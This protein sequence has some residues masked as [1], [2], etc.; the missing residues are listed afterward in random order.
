MS[1]LILLLF[2]VLITGCEKIGYIVIIDVDHFRYGDLQQIGRILK[3]EGFETVVWEGKNNIPK[4][5]NEVYSLYKKQLSDNAYYFVDVYLTYVKDVPNS[6]A[7]NF[8]IEVHNVY[9]GMNSAELKGEIDEIGDLIYQE[10]V[11]K[12]DKGNVSIKRKAH[13]SGVLRM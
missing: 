10:L 13:L 5:S 9:I 7:R 11:P 1:K 3:Y 4:Y 2:F 6:I 12:A 8:K